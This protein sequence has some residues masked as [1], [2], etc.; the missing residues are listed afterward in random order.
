MDRSRCLSRGS[1]ASVVVVVQGGFAIDGVALLALGRLRLS[2][3]L[4]GLG[5][6]YS[7]ASGLSAT[8]C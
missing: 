3:M 4:L 1:Q 7:I 8:D 5:V 6:D 2:Q